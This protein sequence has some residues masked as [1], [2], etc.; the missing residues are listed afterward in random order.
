MQ[1]IDHDLRPLTS[2][3]GIRQAGKLRNLLAFSIA[4]S[5]C[6][7]PYS[8]GIN[9]A[10]WTQLAWVMAPMTFTS[11][12]LSGLQLRPA[13][14]PRGIRCCSRSCQIGSRSGHVRERP[15]CLHGD[16]SCPDGVQGRLDG[17][18]NRVVC[19]ATLDQGLPLALEGKLAG[20]ASA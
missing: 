7:F 4:L 13:S 16:V 3:I 8:D 14:F 17:V 6:W 9:T 2:C 11:Q 5:L 20:K 12:D 18:D 1:V 15:L 19:P 10:A